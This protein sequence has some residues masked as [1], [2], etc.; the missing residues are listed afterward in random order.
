VTDSRQLNGHAARV[1]IVVTV[2]L[3]AVAALSSG[4]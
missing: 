1:T 2:A 4:I 3:F